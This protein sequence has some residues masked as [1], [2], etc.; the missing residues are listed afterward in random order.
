MLRCYFRCF[1]FEGSVASSGALLL[2]VQLFVLAASGAYYLL[3]SY[4]THL[5]PIV[6]WLCERSGL[7]VGEVHLVHP[8]SQRVGP[9]AHRTVRVGRSRP[10]K[11]NKNIITIFNSEPCYYRVPMKYRYVT[12]K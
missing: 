4:S 3:F 7:I 9:A 11:Q 2:N 10:L 6:D 8:S 5:P 1:I 12:I